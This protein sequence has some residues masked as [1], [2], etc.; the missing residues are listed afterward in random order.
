MIKKYLFLMG[1][2]L[3]LS[4]CNVGT[5]MTPAQANRAVYVDRQWR[6][7]QIIPI[8]AGIARNTYRSEYRVGP[9]DILSIIVWNH[10]ELTTPY[11]QTNISQMEITPNM[12]A[13]PLQTPLSPGPTPGI[14]VDRSG[15]IFFPF[16]GRVRVSGLTLNQIRRILE[17]RLS[18]YIKDP[19]ITVNVASFRSKNVY[20]IGEVNKS[21]IAPI[22]DVPMTIMD[23]INLAG[24]IDKVSSDPTHIFVIRGSYLYPEVYWLNASSP[25]GLLLAETFPL[26]PRD[27]VYVSTATV[28]SWNR[29]VSQILPTVETI[30]YTDNLVNNNR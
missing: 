20:V 26:Q 10:P 8:T 15:Y 7:P 14:L 9:Q 3:A 5:Y 25:G 19:Q 13:T 21:L 27:I 28:V 11:V 23:A 16:A 1:L 18:L 22:T 12:L 17:R 6:S 29:V 24:G 4:G 30:W 2:V